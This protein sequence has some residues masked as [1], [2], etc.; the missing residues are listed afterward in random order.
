M[1]KET[2]RNN[3]TV[4]VVDK[5]GITF[6]SKTINGGFADEKKVFSFSGRVLKNKPT[7]IGELTLTAAQNNSFKKNPGIK[8]SSDKNNNIKSYLKT[9]LKNTTKDSSGNI[10]S[11][12]YNLVYTGKEDVS[13]SNRVKYD[14]SNEVKTIRTVKTG[15]TGVEF[16]S[17]RLSESGEDRV[18]TVT[19]T[20]GSTFKLA[21]TEF[22]DSL[23]SATAI[24]QGY[25]EQIVLSSTEKSILSKK[26]YNSEINLNGSNY[27]IITATMGKSGKYSFVQKFPAKKSTTRYAVCV[28]AVG[29]IGN[30]NGWSK[31][32]YK[33][34]EGWYCKTLYQHPNPKLILRVTK[35]SDKYGIN[36]NA[37][38]VNSVDYVYNGVF[39]EKSNTPEFK[40]VYNLV[41]DGRTLAIKSGASGDDLSGTFGDPVFSNIDSS[42]SDWTNSVAAKNGGTEI[43]IWNADA[44]LG[45]PATTATLTLYAK[46]IKW[47]TKSVTMSLDLDDV[48]V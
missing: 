9:V 34:W 24:A 18:V 28:E 1:A 7:I 42:K 44:V 15:I 2:L 43:Q 37:V 33:G 5:N 26:N 47:G 3:N 29:V 19:G 14:L 21:I 40:L 13:V 4:E 12:T 25:K 16:G 39:N 10:I 48:F 22:T 8:P 17:T 36:G 45:S 11:Y 20:P 6:S 32:T 27:N 38:G 41:S 46:I 30:W 35:T 31:G 23:P